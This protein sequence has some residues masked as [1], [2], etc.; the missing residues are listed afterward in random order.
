MR[1]V[2]AA[3]VFVGGFLVM[4]CL[5]AVDYQRQSLVGQRSSASFLANC[6]LLVTL[7]VQ[8][9]RRSN[10]KAVKPNQTETES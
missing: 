3:G 7:S 5:I 2:S 6:T 8:R 1:C 9:E 10:G 4:E